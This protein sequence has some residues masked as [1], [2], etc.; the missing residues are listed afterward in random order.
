M[1]LADDFDGFLI[2]LDGVVWIGREPV[3]GS[4][5]ALQEL[6]AAGK[7]LVFVTNNPGRPPAAYAERLRGLG[8][9]VDEERIVTAG[10]VAA[11]LAGEA[12]G[13]AGSALVIGAEPLR[14]MVAATG[15]R[16]V[17]APEAEG[18]AVVV[19]SGHKGFDYAE[20][21]AAKAA[22]D[23]GAELI[24]TSRDPTMPYPGGELP[25]TGAVLAA[26]E[27]A[28]GRRAT[29]A[30]KPERHL[31]E[32]AAEQAGGGRLAMVG[33]RI[34]SD[35]EGGRRAGLETILVLSGTTSRGHAASA[36]PPPDHVL[37]D[38]VGLLR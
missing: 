12:A 2:D 1:A 7:R 23:A 25:G 20:L 24:A 22:L 13:P 26:V 36:D 28:S 38:L 6:L 8:V 3:P 37:D 33:D 9:E 10:I 19:V 34:S 31:F 11:R 35:V 4:A 18:A 21:R 15:A 5:E 27:V 14:E 17:A 32:L 30:G 16:V 29:I